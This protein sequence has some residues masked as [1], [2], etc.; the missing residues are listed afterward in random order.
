MS[1]EKIRSLTN[2]SRGGW[3]SRMQTWK[4]LKQLHHLLLSWDARVYGMRAEFWV[5]KWLLHLPKRV[6]EMGMTCRW[7]VGWP[8]Q[9]ELEGGK[10][11]RGERRTLWP[12]QPSPSMTPSSSPT[13]PQVM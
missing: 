6:G 9:A 10:A 2:N 12:Q 7:G 1:G 11:W 3:G 5:G 13:H 8:G 4:V